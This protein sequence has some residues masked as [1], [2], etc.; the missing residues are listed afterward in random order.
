MTAA[1]NSPRL[2]IALV[3]LLLGT[4]LLQ[5]ALAQEPESVTE[6]AF[7]D[8]RQLY[9]DGKP[10]EALAAFQQFESQYKL[11]AAVPEAIYLQGWCWISLHQYRDAIVTFDR[12]VKA[13]P[14]AP[15][16]PQAILQE[17]ECSQALK[18]Y[19]KAVDLYRQFETQYPK[20]KLMPGAMLGEA[21]A[22]LRQNDLKAAK[23]VVQKIRSQFPDDTEASIDTLLILGQ[24]LTT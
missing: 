13:Y 18:N 19:A 3:S 5:T 7:K 15:I 11:S 20:N 14:S 23:V 6:R 24:I 21:W 1:H 4:G 17:A 22:L 2:L 8:A 9:N 16:I 10:A 12:L